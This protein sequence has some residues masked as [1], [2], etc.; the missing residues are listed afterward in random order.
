[1]V[2]ASESGV[3]DL[4]PASVV[5]KGRLQP[6]RMFL[7]D[8]ARGAIRSDEEFKAELAAEHPYA[9][10]LHAGM[11][12]LDELPPREHVVFTHESVTRRQQIFGYTEEELR[13]IIAPMATAGAEAIGSMGSDTPVAVLSKRPR[14]LF[15]YFTELF[16][17]VTNPPL[18]AI[19][20]E[21]VTSLA[22]G[23]RPGAEPV[24]ARA[25]P[26]AGRSSS[27]TR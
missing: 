15:D 2:L 25:R 1:M 7:V 26:R 19:R 4:D 9:D 11:M 8:T 17:Q 10:W 27:R 23:D 5:A 18:D 14:L 12:H 3:L 24:R 13:L 21:L 20:E 16:A 6:G 22:G